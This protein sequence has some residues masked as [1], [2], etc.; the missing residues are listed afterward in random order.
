MSC[1]FR[2]I[3]PVCS[4]GCA[5]LVL[6]TT[7]FWILELPDLIYWKLGLRLTLWGDGDSDSYASQEVGSFGCAKI[8]FIARLQN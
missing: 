4:N 1:I 7:R 3:M 2:F 6:N 8:N 5:K